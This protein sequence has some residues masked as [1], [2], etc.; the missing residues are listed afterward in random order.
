MSVCLQKWLRWEKEDHTLLMA[1]RELV[2]CWWAICHV[3]GCFSVAGKWYIRCFADRSCF[4][5]CITMLLYYYCCWWLIDE[6][7][8]HHKPWGEA[9]WINP[10]YA[11][12]AV[13]LTGDSQVWVRQPNVT[14][15][16]WYCLCFFVHFLGGF[17]FGPS[18][19]VQNYPPSFL[20]AGKK[21][22][23]L[24]SVRKREPL[25]SLKCM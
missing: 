21:R 22:G 8:P 23:N 1:T 12:K 5:L 19:E 14:V 11:G 17:G 16:W 9:A 6:E 18:V 3:T 4:A 15:R 25:L 13:I 2:S 10:E 20:T 7:V 24:M